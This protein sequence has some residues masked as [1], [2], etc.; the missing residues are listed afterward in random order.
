[1]AKE[2]ALKVVGSQTYQGGWGRA[3]GA[4]RDRPW[5]GGISRGRGACTTGRFRGDTETISSRVTAPGSQSLVIRLNERQM[6]E[7]AQGTGTARTAESKAEACIGHE[8][9]MEQEGDGPVILGG[10]HVLIMTQRYK[11]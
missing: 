6:N 1:M 9:Y 10:S 5:G 7:V 8:A 3:A 11:H 2:P 4:S